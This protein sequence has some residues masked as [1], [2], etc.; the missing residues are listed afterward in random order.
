MLVGDQTSVARNDLWRAKF[1]QNGIAGRVAEHG[2]LTEVVVF[3]NA[4]AAAAHTNLK[5]QWERYDAY[6][7]NK[8]LIDTAE[9]VFGLKNN[10]GEPPSNNA[11]YRYSPGTFNEFWEIFLYGVGETGKFDALANN[12]TAVPGAYDGGMNNTRVSLF[13]RRPKF[14]KGQPTN[15]EANPAQARFY[16]WLNKEIDPNG[17]VVHRRIGDNRLPTRFDQFKQE[18]SDVENIELGT[19]AVTWAGLGDIGQGNTHRYLESI[20]VTFHAD[21]QELYDYLDNLGDDSDQSISLQFR[22]AQ[23]VQ[24]PFARRCVTRGQR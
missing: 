20:N 6:I 12:N 18:H 17:P 9:A 24:K 21:Q 15:W 5:Q 8:D 2:L 19:F 14:S 4:A 1:D 13:L 7:L 22:S 10:L 16:S 23:H 11:T 3:A